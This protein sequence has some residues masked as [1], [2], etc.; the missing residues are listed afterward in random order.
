LIP[1]AALLDGSDG[2][3]KARFGIGEVLVRLRPEFADVTLSKIRFLESAGLVSPARTRAGYRKYTEAD[4]QR[5]RY[6]LAAQRDH[7]LPLK[8]IKEQL[9]GTEPVLP[10]AGP[11]VQL[12]RDQLMDAAGI[13]AGQLDQLESH[14]LVRGRGRHYDGDALVIARA[15]GQLAAYGIEARQ[16]RSLRTAADRQIG[17]V[18]QAAARLDPQQ[19]AAL[20]ALSVSLHAALVR[21]GLRDRRGA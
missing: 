14:G 11:G 16:L 9:A 7:Y 3:E 15:A 8:V 2:P 13:S 4:I 18:Q 6:V 5:L 20:V 17:L 1:A 12:S 21:A 10:A 19:A